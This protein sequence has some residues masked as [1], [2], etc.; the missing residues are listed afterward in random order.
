MV[1]DGWQVPGAKQP[2][3]DGGHQPSTPQQPQY[4]APG[5]ASGR[6]GGTPSPGSPAPPV[7][8]PA[9]LPPASRPVVPLRPLGLG[10]VLAGA[11]TVFRRNARVLLLWAVLLSGVLGLLSTLG[12]AIGQ[13][14]LQ[15][16]VLSAVDGGGRGDTGAIIA[17][18]VTLYAVLSIG[19][20]FISYLAR[21][22]LVAP[23]AVD[24]GQR[25]LGRR[26]TFRGLWSLLA[27]RRGSVIGWI[28]LQLA[29]GIVV[30]VVF[31]VVVVAFV[32]AL[33]AGRSTAGGYALVI[34]LMVLGFLVLIAFL[35]TRFVFTVP[36][37]A[38]EGRGLF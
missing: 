34:L 20:P 5:G 38:L 35:V 36:T 15:S 14:V 3:H 21:A 2:Q 7:G 4:P 25:V 24:T 19:L 30:T 6:P 12:S 37:I 1:D 33:A 9:P 18:T 17:G 28:L 22:F 26:G 31:V 11:F 32:A 10:D 13:R 8:G 23:V 29:A 16:R 27:G